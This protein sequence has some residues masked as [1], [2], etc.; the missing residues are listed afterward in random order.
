MKHSKRLALVQ[1]AVAAERVKREHERAIAAA[2][3]HA[4]RAT[5]PP[6]ELA[7]IPPPKAITE[8]AALAK[9]YEAIS[10]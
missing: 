3:W 1:A 6:A 4:L 10:Q 8:A 7:E 5:R 2:K 9:Y